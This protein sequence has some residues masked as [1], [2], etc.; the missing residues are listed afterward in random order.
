[1]LSAEARVATDRPSPYLR[2]LCRH[3]AH[4]A[5]V[6]FTDAAGEIRLGPGTCRLEAGERGL[7]LRAVAAEAPELEAVQRIVGAHLERF[8]RRDGLAVAWG[9]AVA[10]G[11]S[12]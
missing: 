3:F 12:G 8:G 10:D 5:D 1:M 9:P 11:R 6:S 7:L 2:Q 4:K